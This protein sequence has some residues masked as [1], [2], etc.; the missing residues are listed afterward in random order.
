METT[1]GQEIFEITP[2]LSINIKKWFD[3]ITENRVQIEPL[4][5]LKNINPNPKLIKTE[6]D[7]PDKPNLI[8]NVPTATRTRLE[9]QN[10]NWTLSIWF[11][12]YF[13]IL[14]KISFHHLHTTCSYS[15]F[16]MVFDVLS[17]FI[18]QSPQFETMYQA[19]SW[20]WHFINFHEKGSFG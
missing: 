1:D 3:C 12:N 8:R 11:L 19:Q 13:K 18:D 10:Q 4:G 14:W 7:R 16:F 17:T 6:I 2:D 15:M 5:L 20:N 9:S